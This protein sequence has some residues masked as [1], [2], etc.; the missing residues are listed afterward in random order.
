MVSQMTYLY[1][2]AVLY[3]ETHIFIFPLDSKIL[4][5]RLTLLLYHI[6]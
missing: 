1:E 4:I 6:Y 3:T 5:G 2:N